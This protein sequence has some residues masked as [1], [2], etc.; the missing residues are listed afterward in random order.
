[1]REPRGSDHS[2]QL[3]DEVER[4]NALTE[5]MAW[6]DPVCRRL[7]TVPGVGPIT[8]LAFKA[9]IDDPRR[10][11][12]SRTVA[13]YLGLTPRQFQSGQV[14]VYGGITHMVDRMARAALYSA[15][16]ALLNTSKSSWSLR[17][18]GRRL[19]EK[20]G[21]KVAAVACARKLAVVMHR[22]WISGEEFDSSIANGAHKRPTEPDQT[23]AT[24]PASTPRLRVR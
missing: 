24:P 13:A 16:S 23:F 8:A 6:D 3:A 1:M 5:E 10:F 22:I 4:L 7:M 18:W 15:A 20:K 9:A 17:V 21:F 11:K 19:V 14:N 12:E 2:Q